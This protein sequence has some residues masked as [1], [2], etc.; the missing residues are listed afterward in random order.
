M[1]EISKSCRLVKSKG[2]DRVLAIAVS[3]Q[4]NT[5]IVA[6]ADGLTSEDGG[7]AAQ[8]VV[9]VLPKIAEHAG[10]SVLSARMILAELSARLAAAARTQPLPSSH[11]TLT[12]GI[13]RPKGGGAEDLAELEFF[14]IG[15]SPIWKVIPVDQEELRFQGHVVYSAPF[16][17]EQGR[18]YSTVNLRDG[19]V[20]GSVYSGSVDLQIGEVLILATDGIPDSRIFWDDQDPKRN[21]T[22]P[23]LVEHL[24]DD[25]SLNDEVLLGIVKDYDQK[26]LL[27]DDDASLVVIRLKATQPPLLTTEYDPPEED[28]D[29]E[30]DAPETNDVTTEPDRLPDGEVVPTEALPSDE[31]DETIL[32]VEEAVEHIPEPEQTPEAPQHL[33]DEAPAPENPTQSDTIE[34]PVSSDHSPDEDSL[35]PK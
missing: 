19:K 34:Q 3:G 18:V 11:T 12:C 7:E 28:I 25:E 14:A 33:E 30:P 1:I 6:V 15:D 9:D 17:S 31:P 29:D 22:S 13:V 2:H 8:W 32:D 20:E 24:L 27:V 5:Y 4:A 10:S 35:P 26:H 16:P 23:R 21:K